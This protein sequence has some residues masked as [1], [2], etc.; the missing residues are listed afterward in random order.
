M[1]L[2]RSVSHVTQSQD[3]QGVAAVME[4]AA[5]HFRSSRPPPLFAFMAH[6]PLVL[7]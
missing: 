5:S 4:T 3:L 2:L 7:L 1:L 6:R